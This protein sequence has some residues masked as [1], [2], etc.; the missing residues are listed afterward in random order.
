MHRIVFAALVVAVLMGGRIVAHHSYAG[1]DST[2]ITVEGQVEV[3]TI[4]NPHSLIEIR[5]ADD[6]RYVVVLPAINGLRRRGFTLDGPGSLT[7][8][9]KAGSRITVVGRIKPMESPVPMLPDT[10]A[11]QPHGEIWPSAD[12]PATAR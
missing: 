4:A 11:V 3:L 12:R 6:R 2:A 10:V 8:L 1:F 5:G 9:V 7:D